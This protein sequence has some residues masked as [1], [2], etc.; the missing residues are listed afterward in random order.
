MS[1]DGWR[2][3][4]SVNAGVTAMFAFRLLQALA[5]KGVLSNAEADG[6]LTATADDIRTGTEDAGTERLGEASARMMEQ[7][8]AWILGHNNTG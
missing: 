1:D 6:V 2:L 7:L 3:P 5:E 4:E 8:A